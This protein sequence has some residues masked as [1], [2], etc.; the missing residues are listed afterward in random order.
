MIGKSREPST[1]TQDRVTGPAADPARRP[2]TLSRRPGE[3]TAV[4]GL[5]G[6]L[7]SVSS[8]FAGAFELPPWSQGAVGGASAALLAIGVLQRR[9]PTE[10]TV[11]HTAMPTDLPTLT[12]QIASVL[13]NLRREHGL[14]YRSTTWVT[15]VLPGTG[16]PVEDPSLVRDLIA[17]CA[18]DAGGVRADTGALA[19]AHSRERLVLAAMALLDGLQ[20]VQAGC[21]G[22]IG[23]PPAPPSDQTRWPV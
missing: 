16:V 1:V 11:I 18:L 23:T 9:Q 4:L 21:E 17:V 2:S 3:L 8:K 20:R 14:A 13:S 10:T 15:E 22:S 12:G 6:L 19:S 5:C 7:V